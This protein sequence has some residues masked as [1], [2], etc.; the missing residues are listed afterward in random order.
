MSWNVKVETL[1]FNCLQGWVIQ[2][3]SISLPPPLPQLSLPAKGSLHPSYV[4]KSVD[5]KKLS[6]K[7]KKLILWK[8]TCLTNLI[9]VLILLPKRLSQY[10][11]NNW[12]LSLLK[13]QQKSLCNLSVNI[14][15]TE[16]AVKLS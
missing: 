11:K 3:V 14:V 16:S 7:L 4:V 2:I 6:M 15:Y 10:L 13:I 5:E 9:K 1:T 8:K 12:S